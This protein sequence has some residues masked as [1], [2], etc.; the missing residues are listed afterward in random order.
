MRIIKYF[1]FFSFAATLLVGCTKSELQAYEEPDMVYVYQ[2]ASDPNRDSITYSFATKPATLTTDTVKVPLRIMGT[3]KS[4]NRTVNVRAVTDGT[5]AKEGQH[6]VLLPAVIKANEY[7]GYIPVLVKRSADLKT[8]EVRL[9]V[10]VIESADF[11]PGV[12][13]SAPQSPRA[14]GKLTML[15]KLNDF[16]TKPANWDSFLSF[17]FGTFSQVKYAFV[18]QI[19]G[20]SEFLTS[21]T[22]PVSSSQMTYYKILCK[23]ALATYNA[24]NPPLTDEFGMPVTFPN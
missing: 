10:E 16:L 9:I 1:L 24:S 17:S 3:A 18:I 14:G 23:N 11:K 15:V 8:T 13:A 21:G 7:T 2:L 22:D 20:R 4:K 19:T 5:T 6:F 12:P